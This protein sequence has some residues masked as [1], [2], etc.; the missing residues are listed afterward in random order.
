MDEGRD[1]DDEGEERKEG[2]E[3]EDVEELDK[4]E[5]EALSGT[6]L[7]S[8]NTSNDPD[9]ATVNPLLFTPTREPGSYVAVDP[10]KTYHWTSNFFLQMISLL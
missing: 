10:D 7:Q 8:A 5:G 3:G 4:V 9:L 1:G 6:A 2:E